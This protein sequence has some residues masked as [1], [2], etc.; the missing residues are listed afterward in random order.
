ML[1][2]PDLGF[3]PDGVR[4]VAVGGCQAVITVS[5]DVELVWRRADG[6]LSTTAPAALRRDHADDVKPFVTWSSRHVAISRRWHGPWRPDI[7]RSP[8]SPTGSGAKSWRQ[9]SRVE[10]GSAPD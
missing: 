3:G 5:N 7:P 4:T 1:R 2:L 10:R 8:R 9:Q 6:R